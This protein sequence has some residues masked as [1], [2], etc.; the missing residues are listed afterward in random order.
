[1]YKHVLI[2]KRYAAEILLEFQLKRWAFLLLRR[3]FATVSCGPML[4]YKGYKQA[5]NALA[6]TLEPR[7]NECLLMYS[8]HQDDLR[9]IQIACEAKKFVKIL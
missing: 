6:Y 9:S 1:M 3:Y 4:M 8:H 2:M 5:T 7:I